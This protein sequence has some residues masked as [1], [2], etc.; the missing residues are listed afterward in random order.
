[1]KTRSVRMAPVSEPASGRLLQRLWGAPQLQESSN[2]SLGAGKRHL[3]PHT[4]TGSIRDAGTVSSNWLSIKGSRASATGSEKPMRD[5]RE[6]TAG[7]PRWREARQG[8]VRCLDVVQAV[9]HLL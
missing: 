8:E 6:A 9:R 7:I 5:S 2:R 3:G 1:M 4:S